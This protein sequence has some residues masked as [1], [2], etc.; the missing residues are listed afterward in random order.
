VPS[1]TQWLAIH[2]DP[3]Q[4]LD[5]QGVGQV[6]SVGVEIVHAVG[7]DHTLLVGLA[8]GLL[9]HAGVQIADDALALDDDLALELD[10]EPQDA[11]GAGV[12]G[13]NVDH[14]RVFAR[15]LED[16]LGGGHKRVGS[17]HEARRL[18]TGD[19]GT[20]VRTRSG[21]GPGRMMVNGH[22]LR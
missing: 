2:F 6:V 4:L 18:P 13:A 11:V 8:F 10:H 17:A 20:A 1:Q 7:H 14:H 9:F 19:S 12:L 3:E 16:G 15:P 22:D 5:R 21:G